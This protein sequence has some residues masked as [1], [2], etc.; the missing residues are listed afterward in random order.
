MKVASARACGQH[1]GVPVP[2]VTL[3]PATAADAHLLA[4]IVLAATRAQG[5]MPAMTPQEE[6]EW[7]DG[8][9]EWSRRT[10]DMLAVVMRGD[11]P[12]GRLRVV[13]DPGGIELAGIQLLPSAQGR[14]IGTSI[15]RDLQDTARR[16]AVPLLIGVEKDN[17]GARR[18]YERL[19]FV[20]TGEDEKEY[21]LAWTYPASR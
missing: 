7:R 13:R 1:G 2:G 11:E 12:I 8:F 17:P 14:G 21:R 4:D 19:G 20:L 16:E 10:L 5:R 15:I 3:R 6:A 9:A 18:L